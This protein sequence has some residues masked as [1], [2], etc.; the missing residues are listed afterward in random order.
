[1]TRHFD[2]CLNM[3]LPNDLKEQVLDR[4][5]GHPDWVDLFTTHPVEGHGDPGSITS[6]AEQ[7]RGCAARVRIEILM[8][9][10]HVDA[11]LGELRADLQSDES[12]WWLMPVSVS[13][14]F[15]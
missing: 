14:S 1:M 15:A 5:L 7:V 10:R 12:L 6:P 13:G 8:D 3:V 9:A 4:L 11:L 2:V